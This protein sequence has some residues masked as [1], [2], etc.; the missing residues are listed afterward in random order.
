MN[1]KI[2]KSEAVA[3]IVELAKEVEIKDTI[4]WSTIPVSMDEVYNMFAENVLQQMMSVPEPY[5]ETVML[6]TVTKLLV[7]NFVLNVKIKDNNNVQ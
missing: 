5:R 4:D 2:D 3:A 6:S 1:E 7:E